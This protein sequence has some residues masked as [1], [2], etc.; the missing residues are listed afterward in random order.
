MLIASSCIS[1]KDLPK[2][3][4]YLHPNLSSNIEQYK[5]GSFYIFQIITVVRTEIETELVNKLIIIGENN[6]L[7]LFI[8]LVGKKLKRNI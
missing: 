4:K 7:M 5:V 6:V 2:I 3:L 8:L 1:E